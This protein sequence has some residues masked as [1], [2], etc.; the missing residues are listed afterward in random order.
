MKKGL[1]EMRTAA[2]FTS[3]NDFADFMGIN[4]KTY[5]NHEQTGRFSLLQAWEYADALGCT[6]DDV[7]GREFEP[8]QLTDEEQHVID[9]MRA[10]DERGREVITSVAE[11]QPK[12]DQ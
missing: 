8:D 5:T 9:S 1:Q 11:T 3:A 10:T 12:V 7:A 6:I 4:R 2:G